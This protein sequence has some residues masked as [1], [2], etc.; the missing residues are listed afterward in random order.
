MNSEKADPPVISGTE[1]TMVLIVGSSLPIGEAN[2]LLD[3]VLAEIK[4][5]GRSQLKKP[6][7]YLLMGLS[8]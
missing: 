4:K 3:Q 5:R 6:P 1:L 7:V 2:V 8:R